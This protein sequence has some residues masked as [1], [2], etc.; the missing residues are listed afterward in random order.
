MITI[1][2]KFELGQEVFSITKNNKVWVVR[3]EPQQIVCI[4]YKHKLRGESDVLYNIHPYGK[5]RE[6]NLFIDYGSALKECKKRNKEEKEK[7]K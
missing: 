2:N 7:R 6:E 4:Y 3:E 5:A 1:D